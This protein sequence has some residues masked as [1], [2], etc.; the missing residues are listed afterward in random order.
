M[1][2]YIKRNLAEIVNV[3]EAVLRL[4]G[5]LASLTATEKDDS[6]VA[7]VKAGFKKIKSFLLGTG[8]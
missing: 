7:A 1:I 6:I 5:S 4:A 8:G 3:I 2:G